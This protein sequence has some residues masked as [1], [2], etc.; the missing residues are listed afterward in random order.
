MEETL[1]ILCD[2][3]TIVKLKQYHS[4]ET[5]KLE[6]LAKQAVPLKT[7][8][9]LFFNDAI[10]GAVPFE[11]ITFASNKVFKKEGDEVTE[12]KGKIGSFFINLLI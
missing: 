11:K 7:E 6:S 1:P 12:V 10:L 2:K 9:D 3:L 8:I 4:Y 5:E